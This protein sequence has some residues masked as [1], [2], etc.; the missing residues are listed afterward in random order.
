M[1]LLWISDAGV[2]DG[3]LVVGLYSPP[4]NSKLWCTVLAVL[5]GRWI[6]LAV[7]LG[8]WVVL[9]V[10]L[11]RRAVPAV[12]YCRAVVTAYCVLLGR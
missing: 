10:L 11:G 8:R 4:V 2:L 6:L 9:V 1:L 7:L 5:L 3:S 12:Q